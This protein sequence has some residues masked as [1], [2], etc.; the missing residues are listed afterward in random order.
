MCFFTICSFSL[1]FNVVKSDVGSYIYPQPLPPLQFDE[2]STPAPIYLPPLQEEEYL[3]PPAPPSPTYL[4]PNVYPPLGSDDTIVVPAY[5]P[6]VRILNMSCMMDSFFRSQIRVQA[7]QLV[8]DNAPESCV[9][10]DFGNTFKIDVEGGRMG[11]CGVRRCK[12]GTSRTNLCI[13]V[14]MP[15]VQRLRLPED[16]VVTL[17]CTPQENIVSQVKHLRLNPNVVQ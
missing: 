10:S 5:P 2:P 6:Q 1:L 9:V 16:S 7:A 14:R 15:T 17:Q 3:P 8:V 11:E 13:T 12:D 4:P